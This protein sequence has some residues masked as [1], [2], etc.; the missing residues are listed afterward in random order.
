M[1]DPELLFLLFGQ[2][3]QVGTSHEFTIAV[4]TPAVRERGIKLSCYYCKCFDVFRFGS[5]RFGILWSIDALHFAITLKVIMMESLTEM[6]P[7]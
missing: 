2:D 1:I 3:G 4:D 6:I 7:S 5:A